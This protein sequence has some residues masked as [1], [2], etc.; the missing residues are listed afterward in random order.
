VDRRLDPSALRL[1][2]EPL[3][4]RRLLCRATHLAHL[5]ITGDALLFLGSVRFGNG[6]IA[7]GA[8]STLCYGL[9]Q[10]HLR[11]L[12]FR[13]GLHKVRLK[14]WDRT[15]DTVER[16]L[17]FAEFTLRSLALC[18]CRGSAICISGLL[19]CLFS[20][21]CGGKRRLRLSDR[22]AREG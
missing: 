8:L 18:R 1:V 20:A 4:R 2:H 9:L 13:L 21:A 16:V 14:T 6:E 15:L 3:L 22:G 12:R 7:C 11:S 19:K 5:Q 10:R 17:H